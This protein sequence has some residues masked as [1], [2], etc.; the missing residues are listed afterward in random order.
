M[1]N[2]KNTLIEDPNMPIILPEGN[3][4]IFDQIKNSLNKKQK[5]IAKSNNFEAGI[6]N[7]KVGM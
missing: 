5:F 3:K 6:K 4:K 1:K 2:K 7:F